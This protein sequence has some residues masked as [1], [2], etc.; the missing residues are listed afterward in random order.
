M[1]GCPGRVDTLL[2]FL[3]QPYSLMLLS[4]SFHQCLV[5]PALVAGIH[6]LKATLQDQR[7]GWP[8]RCPA[9][10]CGWIST[11]NDLGA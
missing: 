6:V 11:R 10:T 3:A 5:I 1:A 7:R 2:F 4:N 9:M 8:G